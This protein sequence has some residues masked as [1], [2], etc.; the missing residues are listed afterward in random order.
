MTLPLHVD[1]RLG[2]IG[3]DNGTTRRRKRSVAFEGHIAEVV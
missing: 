3:P 2:E 1:A